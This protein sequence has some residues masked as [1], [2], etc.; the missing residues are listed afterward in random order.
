M[1]IERLIH[2][3]CGLLFDLIDFSEN[4]FRDTNCLSPRDASH[5]FEGIKLLGLNT[6]L[7]SWD[8]VG[9]PVI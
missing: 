7:L 3:P 6:T 5:S 1:S 4:R 9:I 2:S 8:E